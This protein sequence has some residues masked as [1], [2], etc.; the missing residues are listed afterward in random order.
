M[1]I[2]TNGKALT[3]IEA[4][5]HLIYKDKEKLPFFQV[6]QHIHKHAYRSTNT[7]TKN[8][9]TYMHAKCLVQFY[10]VNPLMFPTKGKNMINPVK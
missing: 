5:S 9:Y 8:T 10:S 4:L 6:Y 7:S 1:E 2:I 3:K